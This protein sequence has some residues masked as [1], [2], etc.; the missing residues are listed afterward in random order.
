M[1]RVFVVCGEGDVAM[2]LCCFE[3]GLP[4]SL[5]VFRR[6]FWALL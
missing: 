3:L 5:F 2:L 4:G 6:F 1:K